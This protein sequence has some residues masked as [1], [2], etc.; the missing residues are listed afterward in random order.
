MTAPGL[1]AFPNS[2]HTQKHGKR[3]AMAIAGSASR[4]QRD[5]KSWYARSSGNGTIFRGSIF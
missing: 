4:V 3:A 5:S 2:F 1:N